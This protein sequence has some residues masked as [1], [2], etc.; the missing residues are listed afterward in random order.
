MF[1]FVRHYISCFNVATIAADLIW[2]AMLFYCMYN[3]Q[4]AAFCSHETILLDTAKNLDGNWR[5]NCNV[6][7]II[8]GKVSHRINFMIEQALAAFTNV[9]K[10]NSELYVMSLY[11]S[12]KQ[13]IM[14]TWNIIWRSSLK[15]L[16]IYVS[17]KKN[18]KLKVIL[19]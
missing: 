2:R 13:N 12:D 14:L 17:L 15:D 9:G 8:K 3:M 19:A 1:K 4:Y 7:N 16:V 18:A 10:A 5:T 11:A 6:R